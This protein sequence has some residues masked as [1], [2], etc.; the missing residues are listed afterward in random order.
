MKVDGYDWYGIA[1]VID[2]KTFSS[3]QIYIELIHF[4]ENFKRSQNKPNIVL[5]SYLTIEEVRNAN[6]FW[7]KANPRIRK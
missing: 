4:I 7:L 5:L 3:E 1:N 2:M 6:L